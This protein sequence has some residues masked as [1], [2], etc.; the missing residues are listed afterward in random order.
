VKRS[1]V[2]GGQRVL[3]SKLVF[4]KKRDKDGN[5]LKYKVR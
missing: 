5:I 4:K 2:K 1:A 3:R